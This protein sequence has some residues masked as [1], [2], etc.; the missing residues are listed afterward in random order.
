MY[1]IEE[2]NNLMLPNFYE[3]LLLR[4]EKISFKRSYHRGII[5]KL[6]PS[7]PKYYEIGY[8]EKEEFDNIQ[9]QLKETLLIEFTNYY[10]LSDKSEELFQMHFEEELDLYNWNI[11]YNM[12]IKNSKDI[13]FKYKI[14]EYLGNEI[15]R[16]S[17]DTIGPFQEICFFKK[18]S[19]VTEI[20]SN[21]KHLYDWEKFK[22]NNQQFE[23]I[24]FWRNDI[25]VIYHTLEGRQ[26]ILNIT[27]D[28]YNELLS[29]DFGIRLSK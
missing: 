22:I 8:I 5:E 25:E 13:S 7:H 24:A 19:L 27:D 20:I 12:R 14:I 1:Y 18:G 21:M 28:E 26:A 16:R 3:F 6:D 15:T 10:D 17:Y 2:L 9:K 4:S 29:M 11:D 23:D